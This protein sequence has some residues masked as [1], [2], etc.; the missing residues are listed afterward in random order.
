LKNSFCGLLC[1]SQCSTSGSS[2]CHSRRLDHRADPR[3]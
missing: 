1:I 2:M 3:F